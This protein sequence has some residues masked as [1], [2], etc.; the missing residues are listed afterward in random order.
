MVNHAKRCQNH[1]D[2]IVALIVLVLVSALILNLRTVSVSAI[3]STDNVK[4][5]LACMHISR[6]CL[7][8]AGV[9][10]ILS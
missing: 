5:L 8:E 4:Q 2:V 1:I 10:L 7:A 6:R 9:G 3:Q